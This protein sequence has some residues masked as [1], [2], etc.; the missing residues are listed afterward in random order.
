MKVKTIIGYIVIASVVWW[1]VNNPAQAAAAV[2]QL[3][4]MIAT[5]AN[6]FGA[7]LGA[8]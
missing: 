5:I 3:S 2:K 4:V 7:F 8:L 6:G 1:V